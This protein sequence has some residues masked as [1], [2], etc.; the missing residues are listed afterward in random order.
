MPVDM[1]VIRPSDQA[2]HREGVVKI[3]EGYRHTC[4]AG[5]GRVPA[6]W[7]DRSTHEAADPQHCAGETNAAPAG[8]E[9]P[10]DPLCVVAGTASLPYAQIEHCRFAIRALHRGCGRPSCAS[11]FQHYVHI[12][13]GA[14]QLEDAILKDG[15]FD[16]LQTWDGEDCFEWVLQGAP[17]QKMAS[18]SPTGILGFRVKLWAQGRV[19]RRW[20][21]QTR[22]IAIPARSH[23]VCIGGREYEVAAVRFLDS[24]RCDARLVTDATPDHA[25]L[26]GPPAPARSG[27]DMLG[28]PLLAAVGE[29]QWGIAAALLRDLQEAPPWQ[30]AYAMERTDGNGRTALRLSVDGQRCE[31]ATPLKALEG[32][33]ITMVLVGP[34]PYWWVLRIN[35]VCTH[36]S[37]FLGETLVGGRRMP[38]AGCGLPLPRPT[39]ATGAPPWADCKWS[40]AQ[41]C[42]GSLQL[43][44]SGATDDR[45]A[46]IVCDTAELSVLRVQAGGGVRLGK[47]VCR[48]PMS[49]P[50][51][52]VEGRVV[53]M[54]AA[55]IVDPSACARM[56]AETTCAEGARGVAA[57]LVTCGADQRALGDDGLSPYTAALLGEDPCGLVAGL[58]PALRARMRRFEA[59]A[60]TELARSAQ[61]DGYPDLVAAPLSKGLAV[62]DEMA[63]RLLIHCF[64]A[65]LPLVASRALDRVL[66]HQHLLVA[67]EL[68]D[69]PQ[70]LRVLEKILR[71]RIPMPPG[72]AG[73]TWP[74]PG[75]LVH[76]L[77]RIRQG[78]R[79]FKLLF[80]AFL[81]WVR[82]CEPDFWTAPAALPLDG[83]G[84]ECPICFDPLHR[85]TA[86]AFATTSVAVCP[87]FLCRVCA[88]DYIASNTVAGG[89]LRCPECRRT[90]A[91]VVPVPKLEEDA[92]AWFD[93]LAGG[94]TCMSRTTLLRAVSA[95]LPLDA[96]DL[97][98]AIDDGRITAVRFDSEMSDADFFSCGMYAWIQRHIAE[99]HHCLQQDPQP[100]LLADRSAWFK[101]WDVGGTGEL[102]RDD[103]LRALLRIQGISTMD[104]ERVATLRRQLDQILSVATRGGR[105]GLQHAGAGLTLDD[106]CRDGGVGEQLEDEFGLS[107]LRPVRKDGKEAGR[108][109]A[110]DWHRGFN[111]SQS[112]HSSRA[113]A[114]TD[115]AS[116]A[117]SFAPTLGTQRERSRRPVPVTAA[118]PLRSLGL[119][120]AVSPPSSEE[121]VGVSPDTA[122]RGRARPQHDEAEAREVSWS[123]PAPFVVRL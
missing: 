39:S 40:E 19:S 34:R 121:E 14:L 48:N 45:V 63:N 38:F 61:G 95:V 50:M 51:L 28:R 84:A 123:R 114:V 116:I 54:P 17:L 2:Q 90:A 67:A 65:N 47:A 15:S 44:G 101:F 30:R 74:L 108:T 24:D 23:V 113:S 77:E 104:S 10:R 11:P 18:D 13:F 16:L 1:Q 72:G 122:G 82:D 42:S 78:R 53:S 106:F 56:A 70:W 107:L 89:M 69:D 94:T 109:A 8:G 93:F 91:N 99:H 73:G 52:Q 59:A 29:R 32:S 92:L 87:H 117:P 31:A 4:A 22:L 85:S 120:H 57:S 20:L 105:N 80:E 83:G 79:Q 6:A 60:W 33:V 35:S 88:G 115:E 55:G 96:D 58:N 68:A 66:G 97:S 86:M 76:C 62:P 112:S 9:C 27:D 103:I 75:T 64:G 12:R 41:P 3:V 37:T 21:G 102:S 36:R 49:Y 118:A 111:S 5:N 43:L 98:A 25:R 119:P 26:A 71:Q 81:F 110:A 46:Q 100:P 7:V